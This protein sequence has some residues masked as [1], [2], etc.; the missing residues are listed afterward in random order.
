MKLNSKLYQNNSILSS[1]LYN[2]ELWS[3]KLI[4]KM[5]LIKKLNTY[6]TKRLQ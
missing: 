1:N 6:K 5:S 3:K 2:E 4:L